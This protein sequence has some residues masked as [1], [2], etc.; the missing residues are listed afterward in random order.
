MVVALAANLYTRRI[1]RSDR[2]GRSQLVPYA[3][4]GGGWGGVIAAGAGEP[5][6]ASGQGDSR[7]RCDCCRSAATATNKLRAVYGL[8]GSGLPKLFP[9][10]VAETV[11]R[12]CPPVV[13]TCFADAAL[14][15]AMTSLFSREVCKG[16]DRR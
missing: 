9:P 13:V 16:G 6:L 14:V 3:S 1:G 4:R 8:P 12:L 2:P 7:G 5:D 15:K 11:S 10:H